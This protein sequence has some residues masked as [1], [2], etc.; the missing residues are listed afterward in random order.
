[1]LFPK[2]LASTP[3]EYLV[4]VLA[5][6]CHVAIPS[7]VYIHMFLGEA[8]TLTA[9]EVAFPEEEPYGCGNFD[10]DEDRYTVAG[11]CGHYYVPLSKLGTC[12]HENWTL[13]LQFRS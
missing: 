8:L 11:V 2:G 6:Q 1:M 9:S 5:R 3:E 7:H 4:A 12:C 13:L 10:I